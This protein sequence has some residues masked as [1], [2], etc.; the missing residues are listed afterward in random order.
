VS[1]RKVPSSFVLILF[2]R[3]LPAGGRWENPGVLIS[4]FSDSADCVSQVA[5]SSE[6]IS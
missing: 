6:F 4:A 5:S 3:V 2:A 1:S